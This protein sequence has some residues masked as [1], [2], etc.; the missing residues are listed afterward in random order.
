MKAFKK[1]NVTRFGCNIIIFPTFS[2][3]LGELVYVR[4]YKCVHHFCKANCSIGTSKL[5]ASRITSDL[6]SHCL[7]VSLG[8]SWFLARSP[9]Q[10]QNSLGKWVDD[11]NIVTYRELLKFL[12]FTAAKTYFCFC[13]AREIINLVARVSSVLKKVVPKHKIKTI[14]RIV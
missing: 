11:T 9:G 13:G 10:S 7:L 8:D 1:R 12:A 3:V 14:I 4:C 6:S 5:K 2:T